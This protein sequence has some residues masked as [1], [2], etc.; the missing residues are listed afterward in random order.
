ML[1]MFKLQRLF[2]AVQGHTDT[3]I[4]SVRPHKGQLQEWDDQAG[5]VGGLITGQGCWLFR[6]QSRGGGVSE[7]YH[8]AVGQKVYFRLV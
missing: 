8:R 5:G 4:R 7:A 2:M 1:F 6:K 3:A